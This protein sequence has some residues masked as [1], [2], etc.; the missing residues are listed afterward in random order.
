MNVTL[1]STTP[2]ALNVLLFTKQTRL[3]PSPGLMDEIRGWSEER[4]MRELNYMLGTIESSWEF[5]DYTFL[6][7][8]V[9]RAFTHQLVR[10]RHA[11]FAQQ[12]Q[13]SVDMSGFQYIRPN[14]LMREGIPNPILTEEIFD[15]KT[16]LIWSDDPTDIYDDAMDLVNMAY[17]GLIDKG[18]NPQDARGVLPTNI[19]TNIIMKANL[20]TLSEM[21]R[22]RLCTRTQ[23]EYQ[24][25]FRAMRKAIIEVHPWAEPF[26]RV[27]CAA[28]GVCQFPNYMECPIKGPIFNPD[29]GQRWDG[30]V[31]NVEKDATRSVAV[32]QQPA[33]REQIQRAWEQVRF[34]AVPLKRKEKANHG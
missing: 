26:L 14:A 4:K 5:V 33:T 32:P 23:G 6:I 21:A 28:D 20:R 8:D 29:T 19:A 12:S 25:V 22:L 11:S 1:L 15:L 16:P 18:V 34:E 2:E 17:Q 7:S 9:S 10:S 24:D 27:A 31:Y 30:A 13:R 3:T